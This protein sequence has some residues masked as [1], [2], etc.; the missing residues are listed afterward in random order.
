MRSRTL[1]PQ[2]V[3]SDPRLEAVTRPLDSG[4]CYKGNRKNRAGVNDVVWAPDSD[5]ADPNPPY[6][7]AVL[8][9]KCKT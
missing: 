4:Y 5:F 9:A 1:G 3:G 8:P 7:P 2:G 6:T